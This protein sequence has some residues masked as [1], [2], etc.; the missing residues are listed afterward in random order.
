MTK[1]TTV[2][3]PDPKY[4]ATQTIAGGFGTFHVGDEID[5]D[6][7]PDVRDAWLAAGIIEEALIVTDADEPKAAHP[8]EAASPE[9]ATAP[10]PDTADRPQRRFVEKATDEP[11]E[12][13]TSGPEAK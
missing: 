9:K 2:P 4:V 11:Q 3:E 6:I 1:A 12:R 8:D 7:H 10:A 13:M 5:A